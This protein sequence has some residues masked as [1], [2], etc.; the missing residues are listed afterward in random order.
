MHAAPVVYLSTVA[1]F[2]PPPGSSAGGEGA[3]LY[4]PE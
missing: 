1:G 4:I 3:R 2:T